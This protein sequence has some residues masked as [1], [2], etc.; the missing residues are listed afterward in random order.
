MNGEDAVSKAA[1]MSTEVASDRDAALCR[2]I[3]YEALSLGFG[4][5]TPRTRPRLVEKDAVAALAEAAAFIDSEGSAG[6]EAAALRLAGAV[7]KNGETDETL[8]ESHRLIYGHTVRGPVPAYE[9]E[10]GDDTLFQKPQ[11]MSDIA[12]FLRAFGLALDPSRHERIDHISCELEL[13][14]FLARKEA[15]ALECGDGE[16]LSETR[17]AAR[18]FL[19]DHLGRFAPAFARRTIDADPEGFYGNLAA[20][21]LA[22]VN[23]ECMRLSVPLGPETLRLR[24]PIDD[25][26]PMACGGPDGCAPGPCDPGTS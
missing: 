10:Y 6:L 13:V 22:F 18:T 2:S 26:A 19:K 21:C 11:E 8:A 20:L 17:T 12:A 15:H 4:L 7:D 3:L 1:P 9:T 24:A 14:A 5:P 16:M 23:R 25:K